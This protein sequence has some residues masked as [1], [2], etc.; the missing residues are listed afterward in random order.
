MIETSWEESSKGRCSFCCCSMCICS[1]SVSNQSMGLQV[2]CEGIDQLSRST[3]G[4]LG[5]RHG[6]IG[7]FERL[8]THFHQQVAMTIVAILFKGYSHVRESVRRL[9]WRALN[10]EHVMEMPVAPSSGHN[11]GDSALVERARETLVVM[12]VA[13]D[14]CIGGP[15]AVLDGLIENLP[16]VRAAAMGRI[17]GVDRMVHRPDQGLV[18]RRVPHSVSEPPTLLPIPP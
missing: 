15:P 3:P 11:V 6:K 13:C 1:F 12:H 2:E 7:A 10:F 17:S 8:G 18:P 14:D 5:T 9:D 4:F 16:H